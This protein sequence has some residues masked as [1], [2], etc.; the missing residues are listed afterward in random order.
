MAH[1]L[2]TTLFLI[3]LAG[4]NLLLS[5]LSGQRDILLG[6][7]AAGRQHEALKQVIGMFVNTLILRNHVDMDGTFSEFLKQVQSD[8]LQALEYQ[9]YPLELICGELKIKYPEISVFFNMVN[10][11]TSGSHALERL[12][13]FDAYHQEKIQGAKFELV[14]YMKEYENGIEILCHYF[15]PLF[16]PGTVEKMI[17]LYARILEV[18]STNPQLKMREYS[19]STGRTSRKPVPRNEESPLMLN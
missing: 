6:I 9:C 13:N 2:Q 8:T 15:K 12:A 3:M 1:L 16:F 18:I 4:F 19:L 14:C 17:N 10:I 5:L 11:G 7:P